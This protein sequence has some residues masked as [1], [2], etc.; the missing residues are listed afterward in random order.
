MRRRMRRRD[1]S[2]STRGRRHDLLRLDDLDRAYD[3]DIYRD[4]V[5]QRSIVPA[6]ARRGSLHGAGLGKY[7]WVVERGFVRL[8]LGL[9]VPVLRSSVGS[10]VP[11]PRGS[12]V[13]PR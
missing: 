12:P 3:H 2:R 11:G 1:L 8:R 9:M 5:R 10:P 13:F 4:Q 6:I 7:R